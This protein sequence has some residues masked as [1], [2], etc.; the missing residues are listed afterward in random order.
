MIRLDRRQELAFLPLQD[1]AVTPLLSSVPTNERFDTWRLASTDGSL[2]G[3]GTGA[4]G[5]L[6]A[7]GVTRPLGRLV[8]T[9]PDPMLDRAYGLIALHRGTLGR[10]VP[11]GP[12]PRRYP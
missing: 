3:F 6:Q 11:A 5:L 10:L 1:E 9:I 12:A 8:G 4:S 7:T 2:S